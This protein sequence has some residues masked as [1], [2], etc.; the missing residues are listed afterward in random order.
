MMDK[1]E[2]IQFDNMR[3]KFIIAREP[4]LFLGVAFLVN[5]NDMVARK[6]T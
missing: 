4:T 6:H 1:Y 5:Y 2:Q 3:D